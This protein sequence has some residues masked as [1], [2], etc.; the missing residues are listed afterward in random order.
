[1]GRLASPLRSVPWFPLATSGDCSPFP[2]PCPLRRPSRC[3]VRA[4][5]RP[6]CTSCGGPATPT[7]TACSSSPIARTAAGA[8][9]SDSPN[10][11][12]PRAPDAPW[13]QKKSTPAGQVVRIASVTTRG[14]KIGG[15]EDERSAPKAVAPGAQKTV[16]SL[17]LGGSS[18]PPKQ[19]QDAAP[20]GGGG[21]RQ[22]EPQC[23]GAAALRRTTTAA[24]TDRTPSTQF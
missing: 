14:S 6:G 15:K 2:A 24:T 4:K 7:P 13:A 3:P 5:R 19:K 16:T 11:T 22:S 20:G 9:T 1:M 17:F 8:R 18:D 21:V 23:S 10:Q 12:K